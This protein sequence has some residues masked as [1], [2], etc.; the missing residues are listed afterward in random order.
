MKK[1]VRQI[2]IAQKLGVSRTTVA[3][4]LSPTLSN[5]L[6]PAT[7]DRVLKMACKM[8]YHP[9]Q[10]A[11]NMRR[12]RSNMI[13]VIQFGLLN[14]NVE[15]RSFYASCT[16]QKLGYHA[17]VQQVQTFP[18]GVD[19]ACAVMMR[20]RVEGVLL[21]NP[22]EWIPEQTLKNFRNLEIPVVGL[23]G[24][25]LSG[26]P[27]VRVDMKTAFFDMTTH[28]LK[29]GFRRPA[30]LLRMSSQ[31]HDMEHC[32][33]VLERQAGFEAAVAEWR[34]SS[35]QSG[36]EVTPEV[37]WSDDKVDWRQAY[38]IGRKAMHK[39][40]ARPKPRPDVV[41]CQND[42]WAVGAMVACREAGLSVPGDIAITGSDDAPFVR[43]LNPPLTTIA[44]PSELLA[45][46]AIEMLYHC[47]KKEVLVPEENLV[48]IPCPVVVRDSCRHS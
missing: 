36:T 24:V 34:S 6:A 31:M 9:N 25:S 11:Q 32:W 13:G 16:I 8:G 5:R 35:D 28:L 7:R 21:L 19:D 15:L 45:N 22:S 48:R 17:M 39:L 23:D 26:I 18:Q 41:L 44:T 3:H 12:G 37:V 43:Y 33:P 2:E 29:S 20:A 40:L 14:Q 47:M 27:Q 30:L 38:E 1:A 10:F 42:N 46:Q 4:A